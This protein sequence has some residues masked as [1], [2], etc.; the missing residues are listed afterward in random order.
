MKFVDFQASYGFS[1]KK[2]LKA[3]F[4]YVRSLLEKSGVTVAVLHSLEGLYYDPKA[5]N[6]DVVS[7]CRENSCKEITFIPSGTFNPL[8]GVERCL[9]IVQRGFDLGI[10][11]W[12][13]YPE[14]MRFAADH[15]VLNIVL[16][17]IAENGG[18][19]GVDAVPAA[20]ETIV[21]I[22]GDECPLVTSLHYYDS[23]DWCLRLSPYANVFPSCRLLHGIESV[24]YAAKYFPNRIVFSS[25]VPFGAISSPLSLLHP[26]QKKRILYE[27]AAPILR[28][29][30]Y[31]H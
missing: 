19:V 11:F 14:Q 1:P 26:D 27:N 24:D 16:P 12:R 5:G 22:A 13:L 10:R 4:P 8:E 28:R 31:D 3:D 7:V 15:P 9:E 23:A 25:D 6:E 29:L 17:L 2:A 18:V 30:K 21:R 20:V